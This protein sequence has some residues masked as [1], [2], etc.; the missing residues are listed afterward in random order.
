MTNAVMCI[1]VS[2][3]CPQHICVY[4][5]NV[6]PPNKSDSLKWNKDNYKHSNVITSNKA[7]NITQLS[8]WYSSTDYQKVLLLHHQSYD[9]EVCTVQLQYSSCH[10]MT[11]ITALYY[12]L[13]I[14]LFIKLF[15]VSWTSFSGIWPSQSQKFQ[16]LHRNGQL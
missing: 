11:V 5:K 3:P 2:K 16:Y 10:W 12:F 14:C 9:S 6:Y 7:G 15:W 8:F 13:S 1:W 4:V